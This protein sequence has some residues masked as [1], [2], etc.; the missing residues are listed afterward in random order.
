MKIVCLGWGSL[1]WNPRDLPLIGDWKS[2]GPAIRVEFARQSR[3]GRLTLVL[4]PGAASVASL[5]AELACDTV[6]E[7]RDALGAREGI[8]EKNWFRHIGVWPGNQYSPVLL[9]D[10]TSWASDRSIDHVVWTALPPKF[11]R[12]E[13]IPS[14][15]EVIEYL[16]TLKGEDRE[17]AKNYIMQAPQQIDTTYR[18]AIKRELGWG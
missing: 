11:K 18:R 5:W 10:L 1:I 9:P 3:D 16:D 8:P 15:H 14:E 12:S 6:E 17:K 13:V 4:T 7:A 2:D